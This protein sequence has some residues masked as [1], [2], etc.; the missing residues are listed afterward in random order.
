MGTSHHEPLMRAHAE[1]HR[2]GDKGTWNYEKNGERRREFWRGAVAG[3][4]DYEK[5]VTL[6]M[7]GDGDEPMGEGAN[8][9]L[10]ER[11][12]SDQRTILAEEKVADPQ[13]WALYKEVQEYYERGMRVPD[14][15]TLLWCDDNWGHIRRLPTAEERARPGGAG[16]YYQF[17]YVGSPRSYKWINVTPLPKVW[18]QMH[19][20]WKHDATRLWIVNVAD[21]KPM[22]VPIEFFLQYAWDPSRWPATRLQEY[23]RLFAA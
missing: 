16:I 23:L 6:G 17:D 18:E 14:D 19:L 13:V 1:W 20:A 15:V 11:I 5:V 9:A 21:L 3:T 10:L 4:R 8:V 22:E 12:V 7:R 2:G